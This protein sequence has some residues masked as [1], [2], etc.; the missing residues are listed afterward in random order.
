MG[1]IKDGIMRNGLSWLSG[2]PQTDITGDGRIRIENHRGI[3]NFTSESVTVDAPG[4]SIII[5]GDHLD[6][7]YMSGESIEITGRISNIA[8]NHNGDLR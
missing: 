8:Y 5:T 6:I 3:Y 1:K 2:M 4:M 7:R